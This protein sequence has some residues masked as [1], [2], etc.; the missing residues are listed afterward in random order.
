MLSQMENILQ[1][2]ST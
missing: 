1:W 2:K